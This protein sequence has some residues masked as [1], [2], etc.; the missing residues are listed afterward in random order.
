MIDKYNS[1]FIMSKQ[2]THVHRETLN[3]FNVGENKTINKINMT[4]KIYVE[5]TMKTSS[6]I[7]SVA[8]SFANKN[9]RNINRF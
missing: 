9:V 3:R 1:F 7:I 2:K 6:N 4:N 8:F 5:L